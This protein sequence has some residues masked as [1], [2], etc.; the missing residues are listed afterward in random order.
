VIFDFCGRSS[1]RSSGWGLAILFGLILSVAAIVGDCRVAAQA[2]RAG[3]GRGAMLPGMGGI[4]DRI[5]SP[6]LAIPVMY[7]MMLFTV[8]LRWVSSGA[9]M[10]ERYSRPEMVRIFSEEG[11]YARW[12]EVELAVCEVHANAV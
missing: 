12:L 7:Y 8:F 4:L 5:D 6:L 1:R 10:I 3:Q 11:K 9:T 2:R